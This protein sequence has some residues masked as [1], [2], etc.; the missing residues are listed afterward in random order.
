MA[1]NGIKHEKR[2]SYY[3]HQTGTAERSW[4][5]LFEMARSLL[6]EA[7]LPKYLLTYAVMTARISETDIT[8]SAYRAHPMALLP[9]PK[10][11][12][13]RSGKGVFVGYDRDSPSYL[14]YDPLNKTVSKNR[15]VNATGNPSSQL[16][17]AI[18]VPEPS[19]TGPAP[20]P[21]RN[22]A[23][24]RQPPDHLKDYVDAESIDSAN[25]VDYC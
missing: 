1:R 18:P 17:P 13:P 21:R 22:P 15:L 23:R 19:P 9:N 20:E 10:K 16:S 4:R 14:V 12:G 3:P 11:H 8:L 24:P 25:T 5:T 2:A 6:L 7:K